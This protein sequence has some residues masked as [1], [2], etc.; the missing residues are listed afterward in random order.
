M[1]DLFAEPQEAL[2]AGATV[3]RG[4]A[5][6][7]AEALL[8]G[9]E[10]VAAAAPFRHMVTPGG[11]TMSVA[12]TN[13]G[14]AGWVSDRRGYRY[15]AIDPDGGRPWPAMP[16]AFRALATD[17]AQA[18]GYP[19]FVPDAC[20]VNRYRP[21]D[22]LT[23]HQDRNERDYG[24]PIVS[25]SLGLPA[26]FLFGGDRRTDRPRRIPL[27]HGDVVV[28]GGPSRLAFHGVAPMKDG[29]HPATGAIRINLTFR[30]AR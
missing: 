12:M 25:V 7:V 16:G 21:G 28:W 24:H 8:A 10:Q 18:A 15:D 1:H 19:G 20:L 14:P 3:L 29:T 26:T 13:C 11:F 2:A 17:A 6:P 9:V 23:L 27:H 22:R 5:L 4:H 30:V